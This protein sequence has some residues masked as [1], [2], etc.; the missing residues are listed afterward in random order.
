MPTAPI[1][2]S[3]FDGTVTRNDFYRLIIDHLLPPD[4]PDFWTQYVE[5]RIS[6]FE[7]LRLTYL[8]APAGEPA[9]RELIGRMQ[10]DPELAGCVSALHSAGWRVRV[11]SAGCRWYIDEILKQAGVHL[12]VHTNPGAIDG[13]RLRMDLPVESPFFD[14]GTGIDKVAVVRKSLEEGAAVAYAGDGLTDIEPARLVPPRLRFARSSL[15]DSLRRM[16]EDF[17]PFQRWCEIAQALL[18]EPE[19][20]S[21]G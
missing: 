12:E 10:P 21:A 2:I 17:R 6:H 20:G 5:G 8:A 15:A 7:A 13:G 1:L 3:D 18:A 14:K 19:S 9:L 16:G 4:A 11:V